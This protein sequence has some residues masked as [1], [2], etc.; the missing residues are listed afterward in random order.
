VAALLPAT[1][2]CWP[3]RAVGRGWR[4]RE[5]G[6]ATLLL[7]HVNRSSSNRFN[8]GKVKVETAGKVSLGCGQLSVGREVTNRVTIK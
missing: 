2:R 1:A 3:L 7:A 5:G 4:R 6:A 8:N